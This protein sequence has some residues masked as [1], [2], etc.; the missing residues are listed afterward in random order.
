[1]SYNGD[2]LERSI[3]NSILKLKLRPTLP[4]QTCFQESLVY[5]SDWIIEALPIICIFGVITN[6][7][8]IG[9][10]LNPRL[11]DQSF[12]YM[13]ANSVSDLIYVTLFLVDY[14]VFKEF[15]FDCDISN[16]YTAQMFYFL[17]DDYFSSS[18]AFFAI[19][20]D[21]VLSFER[22]MI[23]TNKRYWIKYVD[24][25]LLYFKILFLYLVSQ[26]RICFI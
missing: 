5:M 19:L 12:K 21:L 3:R 2:S 25:I 4:N 13:L 16:T 6:L 18:C 9:I 15:C 20:T 22:L 17:V 11:N 10:F 7:I 14:Y 23:V 1:M 24:K 8:N 26:F